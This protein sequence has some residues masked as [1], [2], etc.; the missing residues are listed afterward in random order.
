MTRRCGGIAATLEY[1]KK[2]GGLSKMK[3]FG[4]N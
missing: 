3:V 1:D 2:V 4:A